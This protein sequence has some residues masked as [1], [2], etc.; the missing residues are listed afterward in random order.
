MMRTEWDRWRRWSQH[1]RGNPGSRAQT[2]VSVMV[3]GEGVDRLLRGGAAVH[4]WGRRCGVVRYE[5][6]SSRTD[7]DEQDE[8]HGRGAAV[9]EEGE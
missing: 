9:E 3:A 4:L 5:R 2:T 1:D 6:R 8:G 7:T